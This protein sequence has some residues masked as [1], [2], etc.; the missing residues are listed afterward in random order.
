MLGDVGRT[1]WEANKQSAGKCFTM[2]LT[3][4]LHQ[5]SETALLT[6]LEL[7]KKI[8]NSRAAGGVDVPQLEGPDPAEPGQSRVQAHL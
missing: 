4:S 5:T 6:T 1:L 7:L 8:K 3:E 2:S